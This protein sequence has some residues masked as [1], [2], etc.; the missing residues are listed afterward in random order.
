MPPLACGS[1]R[2]KYVDERPWHPSESCLLRACR[3]IQHIAEIRMPVSCSDN[4]V[5][6]GIF[7]VS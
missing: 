2:I 6:V 1:R 3:R 7:L 4:L 5:G